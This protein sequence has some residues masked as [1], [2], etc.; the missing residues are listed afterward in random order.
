METLLDN[1]T[2]VKAIYGN[3]AEH[4]QILCKIAML[5]DLKNSKTMW[6]DYVESGGFSELHRILLF[7]K[8]DAVRELGEHLRNVGN[9][10]SIDA[11]DAKG[12]SALAW[13]TEFLWADAVDCLL[14]F[15]ASVRQ[16]RSSA[17]TYGYSPLLHLA[18]AGTRDGRHV[19]RLER[20]FASF[21]CYG[22]DF[23]AEDHESWTAAHIAASWASEV[24]LR[25][26]W[27]W[28]GGT[29]SL[30]KL[31]DQWRTPFDLALD[32]GAAAELQGLLLVS[33]N[34]K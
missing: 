20:I 30:T 23:E 10:Q 8:V 19:G 16:L 4:E 33:S 3:S 11:P 21:S 1:A 13:A 14:S 9:L 28:A 17:I 12:R 25:L 15:G 24:S 26:L 29:L 5:F 31:T 7:S 34:P 27:K 18:L 2:V 6:C 22:Y 32:A